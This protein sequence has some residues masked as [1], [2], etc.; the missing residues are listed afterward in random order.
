MM[1]FKWLS[2]AIITLLISSVV[3][4]EGITEQQYS[5]IKKLG[6]LNG[7]ALNCRFLAETQRMKKALVL[8][9]PKRR[10]FGEVFDAE[11]N[12]AFL[13]FI[14]NRSVCPKEAMLSAEVDAA[15]V[16]LDAAFADK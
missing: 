5:A 14:E 15:I 3:R 16:K 13:S 11:T 8:A 6:E 12:T 4:A 7:I 10:Q 2:I 9:L 1:R